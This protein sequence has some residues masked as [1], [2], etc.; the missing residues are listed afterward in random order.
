M[1]LLA[2]WFAFNVAFKVAC[3]FADAVMVPF[4]V[5]V[6]FKVEF[7]VRKCVIKKWR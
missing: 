3:M 6:E 5:I 7:M 2:W 4:V 1:V